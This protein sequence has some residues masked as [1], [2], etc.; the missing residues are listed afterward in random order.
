MVITIGSVERVYELLGRSREQLDEAS[1]TMRLEE[2]E[3]F[4]KARHGNKFYEEA[5]FATT[6]PSTGASNKS[7]NTYFP[8]KSGTE[9]TVYVNGVLR[10]KT[11]DYSYSDSVLT[12]SSTMNLL[13]GDKIAFEYIPAF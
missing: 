12:F 7:Y 8:V 9:P 4:I 5:T 11:T 1:V 10:V 6:I 3:R 2:A 13:S